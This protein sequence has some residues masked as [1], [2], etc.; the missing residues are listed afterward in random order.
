[1]EDS[2]ADTQIDKPTTRF[3][4]L[5]LRMQNDKMDRKSALEKESIGR[6]ADLEAIRGYTQKL[7][8]KVHELE[9]A[10]MQAPAPHS[11]THLL[12]DNLTPHHIIIGG[13]ATD[14]DE[15]L[16]YIEAILASLP[17]H[18]R[19]RHPRPVEPRRP[20]VA[21]SACRRWQYRST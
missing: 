8:E 6:R 5:Q 17:M 2:K 12:A 15:K 13:W 10:K 11:A 16:A 4:D 1:M 14:H 19:G 18:V 21:A 9:H 20:Y 7:A 3:N